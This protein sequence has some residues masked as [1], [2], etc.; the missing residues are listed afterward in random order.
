MSLTLEQRKARDGKLTASRIACLMTGNAEKIMDLWREMVGDPSYV[1]EDL[2]AVWPVQ[3]GSA[4]EQLNL[5]WYERKTGRKATC[6]G[7]VVVHPIHTYAACTLDGYDS[8]IDAVI[9]CKHVGGFEQRATV[10]AR[11]MPQVQ[12]QMMVTECTKAVLSLIEGAREPALEE[13]AYDAAYCGELWARAAAFMLCVQ[14]LTPPVALPAVAAPVAKP[15]KVYDMAS[16]NA[17][18]EHAGI[19]LAHRDAAKKFDGAAKELKALVAADAAKAHGHG[20]VA[21][22]DGRG[23]TIKEA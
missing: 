4:T 3:L 5:D 7:E 6:R 2:S 18:G 20:I 9:E 8:E 21:V 19:W 13:I 12:W 17:W 14:T 16:S 15:A 11:Y 1:D 22:R 23:V 10:I